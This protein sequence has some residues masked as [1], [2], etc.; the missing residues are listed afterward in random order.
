MPSAAGV[1][2]CD[3]ADRLL[4]AFDIFNSTPNAR[5]TANA[6]LTFRVGCR[7]LQS[8]HSLFSGAGSRNP[9]LRYMVFL[10]PLSVDRV[11]DPKF[12]SIY[13]H[14]SSLEVRSSAQLESAGACNSFVSWLA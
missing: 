4:W 11:T 9:A 5:P 14:R 3:P 2:G 12:T 10:G 6:S 7:S 13:G 1:V 8:L